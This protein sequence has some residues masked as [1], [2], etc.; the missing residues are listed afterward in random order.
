MELMLTGRIFKAEEADELGLL[1]ALVEPEALQEAAITL[2]T[3]IAENSEYGVW[4][5]KKG[6]WNNM[7][8]PGL[9]HA[10]DIENR[11]QVLG[12]FTGCLE[13]RMAA[14]SEGRAPKW[15]PL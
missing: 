7:D 4:M 13:E 12:Y 15:K 1:N 11:T 9:R 2:A 5:T 14:F 8:A 6:F 3:S 10:M